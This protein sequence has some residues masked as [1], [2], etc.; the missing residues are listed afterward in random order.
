MK[1]IGWLW[2]VLL[3]AIPALALAEDV[4]GFW[5]SDESVYGIELENGAV[6]IS[7][8]YGETIAEGTY[9]AK[10]DALHIDAAEFQ[11][12]AIIEGNAMIFRTPEGEKHYVRDG[13]EENYWVNVRDKTALEL[14]GGRVWAYDADGAFT[15]NGTYTI[16]GAQ[17]IL[18][19]AGKT[20]HASVSDDTLIVGDE[21]YAP[22]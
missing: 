13:A 6:I 1:W 12:T 5:Y 8:E 4:Q 9:R 14:F 18:T 7:D 10:N 2:C 11:G 3:I 16:D 15:E 22:L 17:I 19:I 21:E 20:L